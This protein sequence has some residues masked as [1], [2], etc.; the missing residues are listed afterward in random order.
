[1]KYLF[2][3]T[4]IYLDMVTD[5]NNKINFDLISKFYLL[6]EKNNDIVIILPEIV[7]FEVYKHLDSEIKNIGKKIYDQKKNI[8]NLYWFPH[9]EI[10]IE[11][12]K[13]KAQQPLR[14]LLEVYDKN[15]DKYKI[16]VYKKIDNI[17]KN[18]KT[19]FIESDS[20]LNDRVFKRKIFKKAPMHIE[21]KESLADALI[22]ET[23]IN[24]KKYITLQENDKIY[25]VTRNIKDFSSK[26]NNKELHSEILEDLKSVN[27]IENIVYLNDLKELIGKELRE[28]IEKAELELE[29]EELL[30]EEERKKLEN[31][32]F[33]EENRKAGGLTPLSSYPEHLDRIF[34]DSQDYY[35]IQEIFENINS[36][37][38]ELNGDICCEFEYLK[39][40]AEEKKLKNYEGKL[41]LEIV[42]LYRELEKKYE[43]IPNNLKIGKNIEF[44]D[45]EKEKILLEWKSFKLSPSSNS[46]DTV[47]LFLK[48]EENILAK[49]E[50]EVYYGYLNF[51][52]DGNAA[53]GCSEEITIKF[54]YIIARLEELEEEYQ[55]KLNFYR[56]KYEEFIEEFKEIMR[57]HG[58]NIEF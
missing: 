57:E 47:S 4:N 33:E 18:K 34:F 36:I 37:I 22:I 39:S 38:S 32:Y 54:D 50:I 2:F 56:S 19:K 7:S 44:K 23:L 24:L 15:K 13:E 40:K 30:K 1:M 45:P 58:K 52:E 51:N 28:E 8:D 42:T 16:E 20:Y 46:T 27:L 48:K 43:E 29:F 35:K 21:N 6:L 53:D 26:N 17:L 49:G 25:F 55:E 12:Y 10:D 31:I 9:S 41:F 3:D 5:R 11:K 14:E